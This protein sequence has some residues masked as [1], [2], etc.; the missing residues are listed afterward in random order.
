MGM[1][2]LIRIASKQTTLLQ[3]VL[4]RQLIIQVDSNLEEKVSGVTAGAVKETEASIFATHG[5][6]DAVQC[7]IVPIGMC[8][9]IKCHSTDHK[10]INYC[11][12]YP[13]HPF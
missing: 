10:A 1:G 8:E 4:W 6:M 5:T 13:A 3:I 9:P 2:A 12:V 7:L 11:A